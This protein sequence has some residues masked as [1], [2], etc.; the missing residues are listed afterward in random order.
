MRN[1]PGLKHGGLYLYHSNI[2]LAKAIELLSLSPALSHKGRKR[3]KQRKH[4]VFTGA[5]QKSE[6]P[7]LMVL[8]L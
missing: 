6:L 7:R 5:R 1:S 2:W 8:F 4:S 3:K